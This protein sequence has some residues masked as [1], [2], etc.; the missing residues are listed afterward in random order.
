MPTSADALRAAHRAAL[1][2]AAQGFLGQS[3][4]HGGFTQRHELRGIAFALFCAVIG[5]GASRFLA[6]D[7]AQD[8]A[9]SS[10]QG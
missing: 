9:Q 4:P 10:F 8:L 1:A 7:D 5:Q 3:K 6:N 2:S